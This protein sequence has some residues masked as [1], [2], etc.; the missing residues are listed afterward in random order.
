MESLFVLLYQFLAL[1]LNEQR[2]SIKFVAREQIR[3]QNYLREGYPALDD[4][5]PGTREFV[6]RFWNHLPERLEPLSVRTP[7]RVLISPRRL[8]VPVYNKAARWRVAE[9]ERLNSWMGAC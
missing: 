5:H 9:R 2:P 4:A 3:V 7:D 8:P 1:H 6:D